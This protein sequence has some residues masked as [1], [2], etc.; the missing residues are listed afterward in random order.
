MV[1]VITDITEAQWVGIDVS[2]AWL[3]IVLRPVGTYWRLSN[4]ETGWS[5]IVTHLPSFSVK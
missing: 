4:Q 2:Q 1:T 5:E 3:D